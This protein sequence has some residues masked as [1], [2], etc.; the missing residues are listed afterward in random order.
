M[1]IYKKLNKKYAINLYEY[2]PYVTIC[3]QIYIILLNNVFPSSYNLGHSF[4]M[5]T[6]AL[7]STT[8]FN[9]IITILV[10]TVSKK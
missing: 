5:T 4:V 3:S 6:M 8:S 10:G 2:V 7:T 9:T 1:N